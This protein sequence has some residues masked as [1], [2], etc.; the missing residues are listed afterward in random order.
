[1]NGQIK[2]QKS[3]IQQGFFI[4]RDLLVP[5]NNKTLNKKNRQM[6]V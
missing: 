1:M 2:K 6:P 4:A 3:S 5:K